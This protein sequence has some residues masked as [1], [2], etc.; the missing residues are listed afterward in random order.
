MTLTEGMTFQSALDEDR[1]FLSRAG[2]QRPLLTQENTPALL[3]S[4]YF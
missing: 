3:N 4:S 2:G 1:S